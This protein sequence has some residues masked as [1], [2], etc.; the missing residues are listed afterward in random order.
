MV[1][2]EGRIGARVGQQ[3]RRRPSNRLDA[4]FSRRA[5]AAQSVPDRRTRGRA[6]AVV[7]VLESGVS[8]SMNNSDSN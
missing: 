3:I 2:R 6:A 7:A 5:A 8:P 1:V 4:D